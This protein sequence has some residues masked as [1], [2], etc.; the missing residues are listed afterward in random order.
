MFLFECITSTLNITLDKVY[1]SSKLI[2]KDDNIKI[3]FFI[4]FIILNLP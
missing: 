2:S 4:L 3:S 1:I